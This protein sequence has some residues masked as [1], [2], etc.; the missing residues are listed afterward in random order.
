[1]NN[2]HGSW[3]DNKKFTISGGNYIIDVEENESSKLKISILSNTNKHL[4]YM[5]DKDYIP[6]DKYTSGK[7]FQYHQTDLDRMTMLNQIVSKSNLN[8]NQELVY[9]MELI[10]NSLTSL[11]PPSIPPRDHRPS[12]YEKPSTNQGHLNNRY[13]TIIT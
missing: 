11:T 12:I 2:K 5:T 8:N 4:Y 7:L 6:V 10:M 9:Y 13:I 3:V 1:M